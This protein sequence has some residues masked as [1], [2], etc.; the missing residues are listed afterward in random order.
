MAPMRGGCICG[1]LRFEVMA[2]PLRVTVCHC[3]WCQ[4]AAFGEGPG[5]AEAP[6]GA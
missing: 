4:R 2:P 3:L 5:V 1:G 6:E